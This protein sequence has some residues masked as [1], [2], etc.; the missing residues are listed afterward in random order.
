MLQRYELIDAPI[1]EA[2]EVTKENANLVA[3]WCLGTVLKGFGVQVPVSRGE[4]IRTANFGYYVVKS[5]AGD[6]SVMEPRSFKGK[7][8][9]T[10]EN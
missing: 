5:G 6:F 1:V 10:G 3:K 8:R 7:Y 2:V 4:R 9:L